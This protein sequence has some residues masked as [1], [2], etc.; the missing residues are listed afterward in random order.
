MPGLL[1]KIS[2]DPVG[3]AEALNTCKAAYT[4]DGLTSATAS[5]LHELLPSVCLLQ[6]RDALAAQM[7][8]AGLTTCISSGRTAVGSTGP[9]AIGISFMEVR[10]ASSCQLPQRRHLGSQSCLSSSHQASYI[11]QLAEGSLKCSIPATCASEWP[12]IM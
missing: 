6:C 8:S 5:H 1:A 2:S 7:C 3:L 12:N 4:L 11:L 10:M 9:P